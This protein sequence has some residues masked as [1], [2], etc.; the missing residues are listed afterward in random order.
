MNKAHV[1]YGEY[2]SCTRKKFYASEVTAQKYI[3]TAKKPLR[4]YNCRFCD[5]WH[6]T[7]KNT[8]KTNA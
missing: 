7:H 1:E 5:G 2:R 4:S 3:N 8:R 6:L